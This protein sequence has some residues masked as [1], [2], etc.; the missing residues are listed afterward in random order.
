MWQGVWGACFS[1][2]NYHWTKHIRNGTWLKTH[3]ISEVLLITLVTSILCFVNPYTRLGGTELIYNLFEECHPGQ[4]HS[5]LCIVDPQTQAVPVMAAIGIALIVKGVLTIVTFG[6]KVP[7]GTF[8]P[9][10]GGQP[11][12]N[13]RF[14]RAT[15]IRILV[16]AC[17]GRILGIFVQW[18]QYRYPDSPVFQ[19]CGGNMTCVIP[20]LYAMV[21]AASC[22]SGATVRLLSP[23]M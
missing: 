1:K 16:G 20:G 21:G 10:L 11:V 17:A 18:L 8:I 4:T 22:L 9:S 23:V 12:F 19:S 6:I 7:A 3:P 13:Y 15:H 14:M 2:F 5:G